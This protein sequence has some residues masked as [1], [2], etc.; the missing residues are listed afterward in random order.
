[1]L[2]KDAKP[3]G[4]GSDWACPA[5]FESEKEQAEFLAWYRVERQNELA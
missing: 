5:L 1:M 3:I 4:D 2:F